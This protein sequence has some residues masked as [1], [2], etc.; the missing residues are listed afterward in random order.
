MIGLPAVVVS[1][2]L[3]GSKSLTQKNSYLASRLEVLEA[4][5]KMFLIIRR[6]KEIEDLRGGRRVLKIVFF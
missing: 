3:K 4:L 6:S 2:S 1:K 5:P